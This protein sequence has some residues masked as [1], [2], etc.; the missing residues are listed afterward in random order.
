MLHCW[1]TCSIACS[2]R[3]NVDMSLRAKSSTL[4]SPPIQICVVDP[5]VCGSG[6]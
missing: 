5:K 2:S 6:G 1:Q 3:G 4:S